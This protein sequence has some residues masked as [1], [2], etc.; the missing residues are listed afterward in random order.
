MS[1]GQD[2]EIVTCWLCPTGQVIGSST[3]SCREKQHLEKEISISYEGLQGVG[4]LPKVRQSPLSLATL[5]SRS[6]WALLNLPP[7]PPATALWSGLR[8]CPWRES[9]ICSCQEPRKSPSLGPIL[10]QF[11]SSGLPDCPGNVNSDWKPPE[12]RWWLL[13]LMET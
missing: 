4:W 11:I 13:I 6:T 5:H 9:C 1:W 3:L 7:W 12:G 10:S 2:G 8:V